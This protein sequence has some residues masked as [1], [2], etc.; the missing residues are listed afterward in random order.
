[1]NAYHTCNVK[2]RKQRTQEGLNVF[3]ARD[4]QNTQ[5]VLY[6]ESRQWLT[7]DCRL[8]RERREFLGGEGKVVYVTL[9][10]FA[11]TYLC[12]NND[13]AMLIYVFT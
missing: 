4:F 9:D 7:Q 13:Q 1:M 2:Q 5:N 3:T 10:L 6:S 11:W 8:I 12:R